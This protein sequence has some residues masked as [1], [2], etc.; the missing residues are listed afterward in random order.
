MGDPVTLTAMTVASAGLSAASQGVA[1]QGTASA[2]TYKAQQLEAAAQYGELQATQTNAQMTRNLTTTLGNIDAVRAA[3]RTDPTSPTGS[4]VRLAVEEQGVNQKN[5]KVAS[6]ENQA[7]M[8]E[9]NAAYMR[10]AADT[11]LL[12]GDIGIA[13][14]LLKAGAGLGGMGGG[15]TAGWKPMGMGGI[16]SA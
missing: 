3:A 15:S 16:G 1:A 14:S 5:I 4:A 6:I 10:S 12:G 7:R 13:S 8:D 11:A 2:D 9:S